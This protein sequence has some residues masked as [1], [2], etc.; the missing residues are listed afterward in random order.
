MN[1]QLRGDLTKLRTNRTTISVA[2]ALVG[3]VL[4]AIA[5]HTLGFPARLLANRVEQLK[6][7]ID[8]GQNLGIVFATVMGAGAMT[9]EYRYGTIRPTLLVAPDRTQVFLAKALTQFVTG[10]VFGAL[11]M[12]V[13]VGAGAGFLSARNITVLLTR[14]DV[15]SL[16]VGSAVAAAMAAVF[17][18]ALGTIVR[19]QVPVTVA[20]IVWLLLIEQLLRGGM[21]R[22]GRFAPGALAQSM[23]GNRVDTVQSPLA[24]AALLVAYVAVIAA[25]AI[26]VFNQ[27]DIT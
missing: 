25:G 23:A 26:V 18:L 16:I 5:L 22:V 24:A 10:V 17:G 2:A 14:G 8:V 27:R 4:F 12:T 11:A 21:P 1:N 6:I 20:V 9:T 19:K 7:M 13:A 3:L 15:V